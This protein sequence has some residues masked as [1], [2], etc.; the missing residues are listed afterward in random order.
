[1]SSILECIFLDIPYNI[2]VK[3]LYNAVMWS[4]KWSRYWREKEERMNII[5]RNGQGKN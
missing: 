4:D 3:I 5:Q 1:M 2:A